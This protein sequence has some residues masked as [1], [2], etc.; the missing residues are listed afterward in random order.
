MDPLTI[1]AAFAT[2][3]ATISGVRKA[4]ALGK[5]ATSMIKEFSQLFEAADTVNK[6][7]NDA[8]KEGKSDTAQAMEFVMQQAKLREEMEHL[9][10]QLVYGGYPELWDQMLQK[11]M[12]IR[13]A[14]ERREREE[15]KARAARRRK[16]QEIAAYGLISILFIG[17]IISTVY[18][19]MK[20]E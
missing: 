6:A 19:L 20:V 13:R 1:S 5:D 7:V 9:K 10:H 11:R 15:A 12:E 8:T 4:I 17:V 2:A 14:R 16:L 18:I 3:Q